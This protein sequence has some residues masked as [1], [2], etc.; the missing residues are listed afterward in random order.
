MN[1]IQH[2]YYI[3]LGNR[4]ENM[5]ECRKANAISKKRFTKMVRNGVIKKVIIES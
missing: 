1:I 3:Y 4:Y 5:L 2:H